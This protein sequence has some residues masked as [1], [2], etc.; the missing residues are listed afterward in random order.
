MS[1]EE[2]FLNEFDCVVCEVGEC[3]G[4]LLLSLSVIATLFF[5]ETYE[6]RG[7]L[8][9]YLSSGVMIYANKVIDISLFGV[10]RFTSYPPRRGQTY[11]DNDY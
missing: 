3:L 4:L 7:L 8:L 1:Y 9:M 5:H 6:L 10:I 2:D 11:G